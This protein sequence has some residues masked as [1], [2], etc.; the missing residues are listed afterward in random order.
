MAGGVLFTFNAA[1]KQVVAM[2]VQCH[3]RRQFQLP[4]TKHCSSYSRLIYKV[5]CP[6][7]FKKILQVGGRKGHPA[8]CHH[9]C[10]VIIVD[11][12]TVH[13]VFE[14]ECQPHNLIADAGRS[15]CAPYAEG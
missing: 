8:A 9:F 1:V 7:S 6:R 3:A 11:V 5:E 4:D 14:L 10:R 13:S 12:V 2:V 15:Q